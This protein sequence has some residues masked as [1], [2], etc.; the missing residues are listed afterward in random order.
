MS[1]VT[2]FPLPGA[3]L[4]GQYLWPTLLPPRTV[5]SLHY[6]GPTPVWLRTPRDA[7]EPAG[8][9]SHNR[10]CGM[11]RC[12]L[13]RPV[14]GLRPKHRR[15]ETITK[16]QKSPCRSAVKNHSFHDAPENTPPVLARTAGAL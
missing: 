10:L 6:M 14:V 4:I 15:Y 12:T 3:F 5:Q 1:S 16:I 8:R 7:R 11:P 13:W 9:P 2:R